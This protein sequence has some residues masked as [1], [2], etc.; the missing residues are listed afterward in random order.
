MAKW[1]HYYV[2]WTNGTPPLPRHLRII[3]KRIHALDCDALTLTE[4]GFVNDMN[5]HSRWRM[6]L[7]TPEDI[8]GFIADACNVPATVRRVPCADSFS[9]C[10]ACIEDERTR[11][12]TPRSKRMRDPL[13]E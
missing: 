12:T 1:F 4:H 10:E 8:E 7:V 3:N 9:E 6:P 5:T 11:Q 13:D 2:T